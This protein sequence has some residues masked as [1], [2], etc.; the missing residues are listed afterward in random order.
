MLCLPPRRRCVSSGGSGGEQLGKM[1]LF[2]AA[3][4]LRLD[5]EAERVR[6]EAVAAL[7]QG[8]EPELLPGTA[9]ADGE[10]AGGGGRQKPQTEFLMVSIGWLPLCPSARV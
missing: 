3:L 5:R 9:A 1:R 6:G 7:R 2:L 8:W 4:G 10:G